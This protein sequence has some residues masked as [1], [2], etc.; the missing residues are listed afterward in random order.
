MKKSILILSVFGLFGAFM[1]SGNQNV[2]ATECDEHLFGYKKKFLVTGCKMKLTETCVVRCKP[3]EM[4][5]PTI[6]L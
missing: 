6:G 5:D 2:E 1:L 4:P 3:N